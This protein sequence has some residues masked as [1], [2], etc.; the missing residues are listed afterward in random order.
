MFRA[1]DAIDKTNDKQLVK[2]GTVLVAVST[3]LAMFPRVASAQTTTEC[4]R[5]YNSNT[6]TWSIE[7]RTAYESKRR[8]CY[9]NLRQPSSASDRQIAVAES[10]YSIRE[11]NLRKAMLRVENDYFRNNGNFIPI[12]EN[13]VMEMMRNIGA[14]PAEKQFVIQQM[15]LYL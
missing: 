14:T 11:R 3:M 8:S 6:S 13:N 4:D 2:F 15:S 1:I 5:I 12:N 10:R 7:Y 9:N